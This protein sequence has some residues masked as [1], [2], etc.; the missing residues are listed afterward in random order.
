MKMVTTRA[1]LNKKG[2]PVKKLIAVAVLSLLTVVPIF[3]QRSHSSHSRTSSSTCCSKSGSDVHVHGYTKRD[4]TV[5]KP[6]TRAHEN[7][8]QR[9]NFSTR[10]NVNPYTGKVGTKKATH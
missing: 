9:D 10:G 7:S 2:D 6:Y 8:T 4:G 1:F 5:V 3:G